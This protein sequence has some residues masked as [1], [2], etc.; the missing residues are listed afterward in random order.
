[1]KLQFKQ[2]MP[3]NNNL[4][5]TKVTEKRHVK[6]KKNCVLMYFFLKIIKFIIFENFLMKDFCLDICMTFKK[7]S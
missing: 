7:A 4:I 3:I 2:K 5:Q 6:I 1:M